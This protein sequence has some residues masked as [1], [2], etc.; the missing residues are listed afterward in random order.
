VA[1]GSNP[2]HHTDHGSQGGS[3]LDA[4]G[5]KCSVNAAGNCNDIALAESSFA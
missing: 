2:V 4:H 1:E 3:L 5:M